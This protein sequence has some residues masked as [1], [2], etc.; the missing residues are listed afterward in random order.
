MNLPNPF[1][2]HF[3][4]ILLDFAE[5]LPRWSLLL[6]KVVRINPDTGSA[7]IDF[8]LPKAG[9]VWVW[10][11]NFVNLKITTPVEGTH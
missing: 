1:A 4:V 9:R 11:S 10:E 8:D 6:G 5:V 7:L 3:I 2:T